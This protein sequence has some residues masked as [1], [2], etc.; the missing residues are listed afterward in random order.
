V[1]EGVAPEEET[2]VMVEAQADQEDDVNEQQ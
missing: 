2:A 1:N